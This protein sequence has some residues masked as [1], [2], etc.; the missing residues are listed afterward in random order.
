MKNDKIDK[1]AENSSLIGSEVQ[2]EKFKLI[3]AED[4]ERIMFEAKER[5]KEVIQT[6]NALIEAALIKMNTAGWTLPMVMSIRPI[7][8]ISRLEDSKVDDFFCEFFSYDKNR[9]FEEMIIDIQT[10]KIEEKYKNAVKQCVIAYNQ[11][12]YII[13]ANTLLT[14]IE[15]I[16]SSFYPNKKNIHM[17]K[18]CEKMINEMVNTEVD[19]IKKYSWESYE[20]FIDNLYAKS[21][22]DE[23]EPRFINRHWLLHG[24]SSYDVTKADC[25]RLFNAISTICYIVDQS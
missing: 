21:S 25:L 16:L 10:S 18:I 19:I 6:W 9:L 4:Y 14:I 8:Y 11:E 2:A 24:R 15:G 1:I 23:N 22:F 7:E 17:K 12:L 20:K 5:T 13:V 3:Q